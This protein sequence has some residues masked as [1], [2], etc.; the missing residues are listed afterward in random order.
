MQ[1]VL[2]WPKLFKPE[3]QRTVPGQH[4]PTQLTGGLVVQPLLAG[5][6]PQPR[7]VAPP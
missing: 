4:G 7:I 3:A 5:I 2:A 6:L 1:C